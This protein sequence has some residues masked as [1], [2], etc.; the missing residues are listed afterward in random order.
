MKLFLISLLFAVCSAAYCQPVILYKLGGPYK[1]YLLSRNYVDSNKKNVSEEFISD[2]LKIQVT[3]PLCVVTMSNVLMLR[4]K[5][6][7]VQATP[8]T[9][10]MVQEKA[11]YPELRIHFKSDQQLIYNGL[12]VPLSKAITINDGSL[13]DY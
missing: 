12:K 1:G 5:P 9:N 13:R 10:T 6:D 3:G 11:F 2:S 4:V 7:E 8:I